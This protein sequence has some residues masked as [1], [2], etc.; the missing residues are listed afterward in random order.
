MEPVIKSSFIPTDTETVRAAP[1]RSGG[2]ADLLTLMALVLFIASLALAAGVFLYAQYLEKSKASKSANLELAR[3][4]FEPALIQTLTRLDDRMQA[5]DS[6]LGAHVAPTIFFN[7]LEQ[8]TLQ[9]VSFRSLVFDAADPKRVTIRMRGIAESV[10]GIALQA[11]LFTKNGVLT[12]PIFTNIDREIDGVNFDVSA[13]LNPNTIRY[14][15][16]FSPLTA[17]QQTAGAAGALPTEYE[18]GGEEPDP[19]EQPKD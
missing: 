2:L 5:A 17:P 10:N 1:R 8:V 13:L 18:N 12:S 15:S 9:T 14:T 19:F 6:V 11:D 16:L 7:I 4:A 3:A